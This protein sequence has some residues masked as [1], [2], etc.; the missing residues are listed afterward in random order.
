MDENLRFCYFSDRMTKVVG[1]DE[2]V[3]LGKRREETGIEQFAEPEEYR[4]HLEDLAAHKPFRN[5][6]HARPRPNG[7]KGWYSISG[8]PYFDDEGQ[9]RGYRGTG[10]DITERVKA[11]ESLRK[12]DEQM[13]QAQ[14][15]EAVGQLTGGV[16]HDFNNLLGVI[17]GN[18]EIFLTSFQGEG[19]RQQLLESA[20]RASLRGAEMTNR[21]LAFSRRQALKPEACDL[22]ALVNG[23]TEMLRRMLGETI[24]IGTELTN[25]LWRTEIDPAQLESALLNLA[26]NARHAMP[27]GG[28]MTIATRNLELG[29]NDV[30]Q[31]E[32]IEP[33]RYVLLSVND[34]GVG[35][36]ENILGKVFEPFFT[37]KD[38][39]EGSGLGLSM[40]HGFVKQSGGHITIS[41]RSGSGTT[42]NLYFPVSDA[43][44][45]AEAVLGEGDGVDVRTG[46]SILV[47]EDDSELRKLAVRTISSLGYNVLAVPDG[48]AAMAILGTETGVDLLF[49][50]VVL[51]NGMNGVELADQAR[52]VR[53]GL[54]VLFTS[55]YSEN[56]LGENASLR[57]DLELLSKP[58]RL[59]ELADRLRFI[60]DGGLERSH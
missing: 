50:D 49:T 55:G 34:S 26:V 12:A 33:G 48:P 11:V 18:L 22:N 42:L 53:P 59:A 44:L 36:P 38:V 15:M 24:S 45:A 40:V 1:I 13:R 51:P 2:K 31:H 54:K 14:K 16:A 58:Y 29:P 43:G 5:F 57:P 17:I 41:S 21:L 30:L 47:V 7:D 4:Q 37:T 20:L 27:D 23:M 28:Q 25:G 3:V 10:T 8:V 60:L 52:A 39:G 46:E 6:V 32:D 56:A 35:I 19:D 9:F